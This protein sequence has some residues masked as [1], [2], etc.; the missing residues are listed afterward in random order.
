MSDM[1]N[2]F[3]SAVP[4]PDG[5]IT[6][7]DNQ[8][9]SVVYGPVRASKDR[10]NVLSWKAN[11]PGNLKC[12]RPTHENG[13]LGCIRVPNGGRFSIFES[14]DAGR[15]AMKRSILAKG[16][17]GKTLET[18]IRAYA[19]P[20]DNNNVGAYL[21][22]IRQ[23]TRLDHD[24]PLDS[25]TDDPVRFQKLLEAMEQW[26]GYWAPAPRTGEKLLRTG[27]IN[28]QPVPPSPYQPVSGDHPSALPA[29]PGLE[30]NTPIPPGNSGVAPPRR[31]SSEPDGS[32]FLAYPVNADTH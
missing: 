11:N 12:M 26:E 16:G 6:Y 13:V 8:G 28:G 17:N 5:S 21:K 20:S 10:R 22:H 32:P 15:K 29:R 27:T 18:M 30:T 19:P 4:N 9:R 7:I 3:V 14:V 24:T 1:E 31:S 2:Y 25:I 23:K